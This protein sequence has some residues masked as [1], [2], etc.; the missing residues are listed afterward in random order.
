MAVAAA[1]LAI[2]VAGDVLLRC[3]GHRRPTD[4]RQVAHRQEWPA[5]V[6]DQAQ[7]A[8]AATAPAWVICQLPA[9]GPVADSILGRVESIPVTWPIGQR[10][11]PA[12]VIFGRVAVLVAV[13]PR[14]AILI[15]SSTSAVA[16]E[17]GVLISAPARRRLVALWPAARLLSSCVTT[18]VASR[19]AAEKVVVPVRA[20]WRT[21]LVQRGRAKVVRASSVPDKAHDQAKV[22][23]ANS[24]QAD[25][26]KVEVA[27]VRADLDRVAMATDR[28]V[29]AMVAIVRAG[30]VMAIGRAD[31]GRVE[32]V[33]N[34]S[35]V[36]ADRMVLIAR[37]DLVRAVAASDGGRAIVRTGFRI[38]TSGATGAT[39][40]T[41][42]Y[43]T[44][45]TTTGTTTGTTA[46]TGTTTIGGITTIGTTRTI[47]ISTTG[48]GP[49]GRLSLAGW[50]TVGANRCRT[51]TATTCTTRAIR[52]TTATSL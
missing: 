21:T 34:G 42:M 32:A 31:Q 15:S 18:R 50:T 36:T 49:R 4:H 5:A 11:V 29:P 19:A 40:I 23:A 26:V 44:I 16:A 51:T 37:T 24:G 47:P 1:V 28:D 9:R 8:P 46:I 13:V 30:Q 39:T 6:V 43:G 25:R 35:R 12:V 33:N 52:C 3:L 10:R 20:T 45:G 14:P 2:A 48:D 38:G 27:S 7:V 41:T 22:A 17:V